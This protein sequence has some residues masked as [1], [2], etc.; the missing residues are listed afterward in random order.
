MGQD[1]IVP[2]PWRHMICALAPIPDPLL[3]LIAK[4]NIF[5]RQFELG[6]VL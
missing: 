5:H 3:S 6:Q 4:N 1:G 2:L